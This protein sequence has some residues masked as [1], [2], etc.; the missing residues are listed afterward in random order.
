MLDNL[1]ETGDL[2]LPAL[3]KAMG[4]HLLEGICTNVRK[5][6]GQ[7]GFHN[8]GEVW[9]GV[10]LASDPMGSQGQIPRLLTFIDNRAL[11]KSLLVW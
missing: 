10:A 3:K 2:L 8:E 11:G 6:G 4:H 5:E 1:V 9:G 7:S